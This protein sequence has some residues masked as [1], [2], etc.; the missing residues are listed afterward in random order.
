MMTASRFPYGL[1]LLFFFLLASIIDVATCSFQSEL[2]DDSQDL[3]IE[4]N[5][6]SPLPI[7][8]IDSD[9]LPDA[10]SWDNVDG[11][12][13]LTR[14]LN[15]HIPQYCGSCWAHATMS[16][17]ADRIKIARGAANNGGDDINLSIQYI[18]NCGSE[19]AGSCHG[20]SMPRTYE[21]LKDISGFVP[22]DT[23]QPY[24]A[25]S[26]ESEEG[27]CPY[28]D[29]TCSAMNTCRTCVPGNADECKEI[30][31]FPNA[32]VAEYGTYRD[33]ADMDTIKAE[34]FARGPIATGVWG[35]SLG[36]YAGGVFSD[37][38]APRTTTHAVSIVG[39]G[40]SDQ[41]TGGE[42]YWIVRNS[43]GQYWGE[44]GYFRV[45]MGQNVLGIESRVTWAT[46]G[47]FT[48][49]NYPCA[50]DGSNCGSPTVITMD[51]VDPSK[52]PHSLQR[53]FRKSLSQMQ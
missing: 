33:A 53:P 24:V 48:V 38:D 2:W 37:V 14:S 1:L 3:E 30:D 5:H 46:P 18:L 28:M 42:Q 32:T 19:H 12:S 6:H 10:F 4:N 22:Y 13:Y 31:V 20:G 44:M 29:T 43:W 47:R 7:T 39:W 16:A 25:C 35:A 41:E 21:F 26:H 50:E 52:E 23:C 11:V 34:I 17:L 27:F 45:L 51:Y 8:Y 36:D 15:Q 40:T 9:D 49:V